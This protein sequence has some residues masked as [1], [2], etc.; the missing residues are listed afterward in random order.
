MKSFDVDTS[1]EKKTG[2]NMEYMLPLKKTSK[3]T[4]VGIRIKT[5]TEIER[6]IEVSP[7]CDTM[8]LD[9]GV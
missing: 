5:A 8:F 7:N 1:K 4:R 2:G 3:K 6:V 9:L